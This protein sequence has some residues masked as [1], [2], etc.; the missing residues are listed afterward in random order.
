MPDVVALTVLQF[1]KGALRQPVHH[2]PSLCAIGALQRIDKVDQRVRRSRAL[3]G[4]VGPAGNGA[5]VSPTP[6]RVVGR[7]ITQEPFRLVDTVAGDKRSPFLRGEGI[8]HL[9]CQSGVD[10]DGGVIKQA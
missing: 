4:A 5:D 1:S 2:N 10:I 3:E 8:A 7:G 9:A 6:G